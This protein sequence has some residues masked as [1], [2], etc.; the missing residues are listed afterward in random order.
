MV[1]LGGMVWAE[2]RK[3]WRSRMPLWTGLGSLILPLA[4]AFI[5]FVAKNPELSQ[6]LGLI[7]AKANLMAYSSMDWA[8]YLRLFGLMIAAGEFFL[9]VI[10]ISWLFGREFADG[11]LKDLLAV[12]VSRWNIVLAKFILI[13]VWSC[14]LTLVIYIAG[15]LVGYFLDLPNLSAGLFTA[16]SGTVLATAVLTTAVITPFAFFASAGRG[17]LLPVAMA[18]LAMMF[19][20]LSQVIGWGEY[21]PWA[22]PGLLSQTKEGLPVASVVIVILTGVVGILVTWLWWMKADQSR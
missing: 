11:T 4:I 13:G 21:F 2:F 17:Y 20:N 7:G 14:G 8:A 12:P 18:V 22:V 6:K 1:E 16:G 5:I 19:A 3:A 15:M 10:A 9:L